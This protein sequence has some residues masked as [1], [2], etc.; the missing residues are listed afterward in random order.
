MRTMGL[1]FSSALYLGFWHESSSLKPWSLLT[2]GKP[3]ALLEVPGSESVARQIARLLGCDQAVLGSSTLHLFWDL[4]GM[5]SRERIAIFQDSGT[6]SIG[7][8]GI[9]R[10]A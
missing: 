2:L 7:E 1:D 4:F 10:A 6:Y 8:W 5:L 9:E 3:A